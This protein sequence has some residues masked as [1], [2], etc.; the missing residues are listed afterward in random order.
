MTRILDIK[1]S[2]I[3]DCNWSSIKIYILHS[4]DIF[5]DYKIASI[6]LMRD[7]CGNFASLLI[8]DA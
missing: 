8:G 6:V 3:D 7:N 4:L 5:D 1:R 2:L